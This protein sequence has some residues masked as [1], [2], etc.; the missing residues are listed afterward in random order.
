MPSGKT[1]DNNRHKRRFASMG[2]DA[3]LDWA[4]KDKRLERLRRA[5][6]AGRP[7]TVTDRIG[8]D[9]VAHPQDC[10]CYDCLYGWVRELRLQAA[11]SNVAVLEEGPPSRTGRANHRASKMPGVGHV[12]Y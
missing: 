9:Q 1:H 7:Y 11:T 5:Q 10:P 6:R 3:Y 12:G 4:R 2:H 8:V